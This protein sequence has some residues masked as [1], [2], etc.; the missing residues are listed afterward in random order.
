MPFFGICRNVIKSEINE[1]KSLS[2][3]LEKEEGNA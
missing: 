2:G 3:K 1:W